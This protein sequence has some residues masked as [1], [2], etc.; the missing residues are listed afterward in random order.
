MLSTFCP[1]QCHTSCSESIQPAWFSSTR[2]LRSPLGLSVL[3]GTW[4]S[5]DMWCCAMLCQLLPT[6]ALLQAFSPASHQDRPTL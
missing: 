1:W 3:L 4:C 5:A 2:V 6:P